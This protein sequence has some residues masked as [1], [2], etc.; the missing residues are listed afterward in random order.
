MPAHLIP[1]SEPT[2][3]ALITGDPRRAFG[4]AK[5]LMVQPVLSHQARGL[6]G[7][8]GETEAGLELT[9]QST[10]TG[11]PAAISVIGDLAGLGVQRL[12]RIGTCVAPGGGRPPGSVLLVERAIAID[13]ATRRLV[14]GEPLAEPDHDLLEV[15]GGVAGLATVSSHDFVARF[16]PDGPLPADGASARD[17][18]TAA[19]LAISRKFGLESAAVLVVVGDGLGNGLAEADLEKT[20]FETGRRVIERL[21]RTKP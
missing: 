16:D 3:D 10:G 5:D 13:G 19:T 8:T 20:F 9:V 7:Y 12:V 18:Q 21:S 4:L 14:D 2:A 1:L 11:G 17:L 15:L 6:W